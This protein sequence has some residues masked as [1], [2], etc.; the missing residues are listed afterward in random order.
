M[1][2]M[3][4][5]DSVLPFK[6][7][8]Q[9]CGKEYDIH[10]FGD[11]VLLWGFIFLIA[12]KDEM[13]LIGITCPE[14]KKTTIQKYRAAA[15]I[16]FLWDMGFHFAKQ[17][18]PSG[19]VAL[20][21]WDG[22]YFSPDY[23]LKK[24]FI[25]IHYHETKA[26][27]E[28][29]YFIPKEVE[30]DE[31]SQTLQKS[32]PFSL[33]ESAI[34]YSIDIENSTGYKAIPRTFLT[35]P[36]GYLP[37]IV[38]AYNGIINLD[39]ILLDQNHKKTNSYLWSL[40]TPNMALYKT[41][42]IDNPLNI[43]D[44]LDGTYHWFRGDQWKKKDLSELSEIE[45][46][47]LLNKNDLLIEEYSNFSIGELSWKRKEFQLNFP[48]FIDRLKIIRNRIDY[49]LIV[50][51]ELVN[52]FGRKFYYKTKTIEEE[53]EKQ[54]EKQ[55][56]QE[57]E[58]MSREPLVR[59]GA[60][61]IT[62]DLRLVPTRSIP[63]HWISGSELM[64]KLD[65]NAFG[66]INLIKNYELIAYDSFNLVFI[67]NTTLNP[68]LI[69]SLI[70]GDIEQQKKAMQRLCFHPDNI[71]AFETYYGEQLALEEMELEKDSHPSQIIDKK[72]NEFQVS[73][74]ELQPAPKKEKSRDKAMRCCQI[75]ATQLWEKNPDLT[76][77]E[78][79]DHKI[80]KACFTENEYEY[81]GYRTRHDWVKGCA[82][83]NKT[84]GRPKGS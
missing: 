50:R 6:C 57:V 62:S 12:E 48:D 36:P 43:G 67:D 55:S 68:T 51:N 27:K 22:K 63:M 70:S 39:S 61:M 53:R 29:I 28:I 7:E 5:I 38:H 42:N 81:D 18:L 56:Q 74:D 77:R 16:R 52:K 60:A 26:E 69:E 20:E 35:P 58:R 80:I 30:L 3:Q 45:E 17:F 4:I 72:E 41:W 46:N 76:I 83:K 49:E 2:E 11:V 34:L 10:D 54:R 25:N 71:A 21:S 44:P 65:L 14:C 73:D 59:Y 23:L 24:G 8:N 9:D 19:H 32:C 78:V 47:L 82:P 33:L 1:A 64:E 15:A 79:A 66:I 75:R 13:A 31:Y 40:I 37:P 84:A